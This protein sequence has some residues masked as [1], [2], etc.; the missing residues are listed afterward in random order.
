MSRQARQRSESGIYHIIIRGINKQV[1]FEDDEDRE[2]FIGYL[3]YYK[4]IARY[5]L[6]GYCLMDNHIH[7][8][9][10]EGKEPIG[11]SMKRIGVSYV[12]WYNR[13]YDR[14][15][16][17]FQDRF[18][19]EVVETDA[20]LLTVLRYIHQNPIKAGKEKSV[21]NYKWSSY[22]EYIGQ[23][24]IVET[25]FILAIFAEEHERSIASF[26][27]YMNEQSDDNCIE[28]KDAKRIT[29]EDTKKMIQKYANVKMATELQ[30]MER[31][32]R[33]EI[34]RRI[35]GVEGISTRQIARVTGICQTVISKA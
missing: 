23:N 9:I 10:K 1:I 15:G 27:K 25:G 19:S 20:Y 8:L 17:L 35:K 21:V 6:Y 2:K 30:S 3:Q 4:E 7:L 18:K 11:H 29:D 32:K 28:I 22:V 14:V 13:K 26:K 5:I 33:D 12:A 24:K 34:I 16:H 31:I